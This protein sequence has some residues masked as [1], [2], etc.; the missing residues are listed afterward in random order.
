LSDKFEFKKISKQPNY[1]LAVSLFTHLNPIDIKICLRNLYN[2]ACIG[3]K[4]YASY[5]ETPIPLPQIYQSHSHRNYLY[6]RS[7][8][9]KFGENNGWQANYIG[10]WG[11]P[12]GQL[13]MEYV[14]EI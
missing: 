8:M 10:E 11:H 4:L 3:C 12:T 5:G 14:K 2:F 6:T 1:C 9:E 7:Q 13:M